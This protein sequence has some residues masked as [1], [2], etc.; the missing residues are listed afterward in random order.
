MREDR[1]RHESLLKRDLP[2]ELPHWGAALPGQP[3]A[4][5]DGVVDTDPDSIRMGDGKDCRVVTP[6]RD[7]SQ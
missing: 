5:G 4:S 7:A 1:T 2:F 6:A 3:A